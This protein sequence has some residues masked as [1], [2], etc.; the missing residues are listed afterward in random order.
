MRLRKGGFRRFRVFVSC[1]SC[2]YRLLIAKHKC[3]CLAAMFRKAKRKRE[4]IKRPDDETISNGISTC[5]PPSLSMETG[6]DYIWTSCFCVVVH[7]SCSDV[8]G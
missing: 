5:K 8:G 6:T 2:R 4:W 3:V 1:L 7:S